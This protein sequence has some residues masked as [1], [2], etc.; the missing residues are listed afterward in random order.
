M[1]GLGQVRMVGSAENGWVRLEWK[2]QAKLASSRS[3]RKANVKLAWR[4]YEVRMAGSNGKGM[5]SQKS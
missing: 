5:S 4:Q 1:R 2:Y 3:A